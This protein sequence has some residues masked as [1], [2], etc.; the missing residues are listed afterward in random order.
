MV[1]HTGENKMLC[2]TQLI[3]TLIHDLEYLLITFSYSQL[4]AN[5]R[6]FRAVTKFY[7]V[8]A[9]KTYGLGFPEPRTILLN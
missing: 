9:M 4:S 6:T 2:L 7:Y 1:P 3:K 8:I 5:A